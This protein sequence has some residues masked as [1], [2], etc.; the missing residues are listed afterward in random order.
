MGKENTKKMCFFPHK[1]FKN[2]VFLKK[3]LHFIVVCAIMTKM[4]VCPIW[5]FAQFFWKK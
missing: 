5:L 3:G 1:V 2:K 4:G